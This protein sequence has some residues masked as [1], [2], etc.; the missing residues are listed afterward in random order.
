MKRFEDQKKSD[1]KELTELAAAETTDKINSFVQQE[2][3]ITTP[4]RTL[5]I[6]TSE[7]NSLVFFV[8]Y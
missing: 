1:A 6:R 3:T 8:Y 4:S 7:I 5:S 2:S